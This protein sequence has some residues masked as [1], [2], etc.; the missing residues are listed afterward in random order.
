MRLDG[1]WVVVDVD[2][3]INAARYLVEQGLADGNRVWITG[4]SAGGFTVLLSLTKRNFY[5]A[6]A[7]H[8]GI[9]DLELF[10][11]ENHKIQSPYVDA[12]VG[13]YPDRA[14]LYRDR[15]AVHFADNLKCPVILFQ[16]LEDKIVP[17]SQ[18]EE[19]VAVCK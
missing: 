17:P 8:F 6:G 3:C 18:A 9:R 14:D 16:G 13:P 11:K 7:S 5:D 1:N 2:D 4:G 12:L 10:I 15:S 19:F